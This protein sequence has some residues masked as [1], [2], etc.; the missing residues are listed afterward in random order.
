M[1]DIIYVSGYNSAH[2]VIKWK[3]SQNF[4]SQ[5][6]FSIFNF[7]SFSTLFFQFIVKANFCTVLKRFCSFV[8]CGA[9]VCRP[10]TCCEL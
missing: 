7:L 8:L 1:V 4:S 6:L 5:I 2:S 9:H 10:T 3:I